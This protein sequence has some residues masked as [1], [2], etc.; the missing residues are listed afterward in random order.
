VK[1]TSAALSITGVSLQELGNKKK[2]REREM[3]MS[4]VNYG[5]LVARGFLS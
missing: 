5:S 1:D 4:Q 2:E 3:V